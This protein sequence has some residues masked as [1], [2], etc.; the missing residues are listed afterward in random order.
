MCERHDGE[1]VLDREAAQKADELARLLPGVLIAGEDVGEGVEAHE[2]RLSTTLTRSRQTAVDAMMP[3][4]R[5]ARPAR[6]R[7]PPAERGGS[8]RDRQGQFRSRRRCL[9]SPMQLVDIVLRA[10]INDGASLRRRPEHCL[11]AAV[12]T[13]SCRAAID[14]T[15]PSPPSSVTVRPGIMSGTCPGRGGIGFP[16]RADAVI[17]ADRARSGP[18]R[19]TPRLTSARPEIGIAR[20]RSGSWVRQPEC[21]EIDLGDLVR[22]AILIGCVSKSPS[23][24]SGGLMDA[25]HWNGVASPAY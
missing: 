11:P 12:A 22:N 16:A 19:A 10:Q 15:P 2:A 13:P 23:S 21:R 5:T 8:R 4:W 14:P 18:A 7:G 24:P 1:V 9:E 17:R 3:G 6:R 20:R 25:R